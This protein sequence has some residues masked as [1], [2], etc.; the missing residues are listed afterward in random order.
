MSVK[1]TILIPVWNQEELVIKALDHL[2]RRDDIE[3]IVRDDG[4][5]DNTL[6][7]LIRYKEEHP[8]LNL[9]V[10]SNG[11]NKGVAYTKNQMLKIASGEYIHIHDSDDYVH[12]QE[13]SE[14]ID[15]LDGTDDI[16]YMDLEI[17]N[18]QYFTLGE[19][20]KAAYCAQTA[21]FL[22]R[23]FVKGLE[24]K[25]SITNG[26]DDRPYN[27]ECLARDPVNRFTHIPAYHYN[28]P[29]EG[30]LYDLMVKGIR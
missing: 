18:G 7:N 29:R 27:D 23:E 30:S 17:N 12:T 6:A 20:T 28:Y 8:E 2:P 22:R 21:R 3:V 26:G 19:F 11:E 16:V 15:S 1:L 14:I 13:Y 10:Y 25:E 4:S 9:Q 24:F 5:T